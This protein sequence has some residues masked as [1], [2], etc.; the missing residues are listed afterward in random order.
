MGIHIPGAPAP[1]TPGFRL[2]L[3]LATAMAA[4]SGG[5]RW[6]LAQALSGGAEGW[7]TLPA[8]LRSVFEGCADFMARGGR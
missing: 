8:H 3:T 1:V 4:L 6:Q 7:K 2:F 5:E